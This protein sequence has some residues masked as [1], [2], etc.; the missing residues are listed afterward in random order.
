[1]LWLMRIRIRIL[2]A[3]PNFQIKAQTLKKSAKVGSCPM[4]FGL[5]SANWCGSGS[6]SGSSLSLRCR[7]GSGFLFDADADPDADHGYQYDMDPDPDSQN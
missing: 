7:S 4:H 6:C 2:D 3:D 5:S 1:V